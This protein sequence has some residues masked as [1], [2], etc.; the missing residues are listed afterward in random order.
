VPV[1]ID[2][3][4]AKLATA[5]GVDTWYEDYHHQRVD[6]DPDVVVAVLGS[7]DVDASSPAAVRARLRDAPVPRPAAVRAPS[8]D[9]RAVSPA[10][11]SPASVFG[12]ASGR[13]PAPAA[14][15]GLPLPP[16]TW[17][18]MIQVYGVRSSDSWGVGD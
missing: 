13:S 1:P 11:P 5:H 15:S 6:V 14:P 4:L 17:G 10:V 18:W 8:R 9:A 3:D 2:P 12:P 16:S 7:L